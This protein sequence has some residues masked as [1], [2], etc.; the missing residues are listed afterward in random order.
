MGMRS[1]LSVTGVRGRGP[2]GRCQVVFGL[3]LIS[4]FR[5][6]PGTSGTSGS[7]RVDQ[8]YRCASAPVSH[9]IPAPENLQQPDCHILIRVRPRK[10]IL[11]PVSQLSQSLDTLMAD[12]PI[13]VT[14]TS[15]LF[16]YRSAPIIARSF[17]AT[18]NPSIHHKS[19]VEKGR[20]TLVSRVL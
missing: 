9:R 15:R 11:L 10:E 16:L 1:Q 20:A 12:V 6:L 19:L 13:G 14:P 2:T 5:H 7:S 18:Q 4:V 17:A 8:S 3:N